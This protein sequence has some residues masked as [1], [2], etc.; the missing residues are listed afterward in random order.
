MLP[1]DNPLRLRQNLSKKICN[2]SWKVI[3]ILEM[4]NYNVIF[5][6]KEQKYQ[7]YYQTKLINMNI[8]R[9]KNN[10]LLVRVK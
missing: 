4:K 8:L 9:V 10:Y 7:H 5:I 2:K 3:K 1:S 6:E